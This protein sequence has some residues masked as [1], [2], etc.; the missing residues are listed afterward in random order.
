M[1][2]IK[3]L[4]IGIMLLFSVTSIILIGAYSQNLRNNITYPPI[5]LDE[6]EFENASRDDF[7]FVDVYISNNHLYIKISYFGGCASHDFSLIG[8]GT[9]LEKSPV[10]TSIVLSHEDNGD[11]CDALLVESLV[12]DLTPLKDLYYE[13]YAKSSGTI[14]IFLLG[15]VNLSHLYGWVNLLSYEF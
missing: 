11:N 13:S 8:T 6:F 12:F 9:F 10:E 2:A 4:S 7:S 1:I 3:K 5:L 14:T 15:Y